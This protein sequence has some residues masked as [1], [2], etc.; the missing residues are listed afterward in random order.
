V[1]LAILSDI[2]EDLVS[3]KRVL[4]KIERK[5]YD[6]MICLGDISGY[7]K[8]YYRYRRSR[9]APACLELIRQRCDIII[10]GNHD[11]HA[12]GMI[13]DLQA[14]SGNE[15]WQHDMDLDP[16]Y[17]EEEIAFLAN[18]PNYRVVSTPDYNIFLSHYLAPNLS[19]LFKGFYS[20]GKELESHFQLMQ[21][22]NCSLG[23]KGHLHTHGFFMAGPES[24]Q[25]YNHRQLRLKD[26]P[27][28]I[29]IPPV[30][31]HKYRT[32]FCI[33]DTDTYLLQI[34]KLLYYAPE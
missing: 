1:R 23:F 27:A 9:N 26:F 3:L 11:L 16:G 33:F 8:P 19:G 18:L 12:A 34:I 20:N 14:G 4:K 2:H 30:T 5:G 22:N 10:P 32:R 29:G 7:S 6:L 24:F 17:D 31:R 15:Y 13:P 28:I 21:K 25:H